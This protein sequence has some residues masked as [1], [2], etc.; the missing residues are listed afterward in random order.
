VITGSTVGIG[1]RVG[2]RSSLSFPSS[3][4]RLSSTLTGGVQKKYIIL[5]DPICYAKT[6]LGMVDSAGLMIPMIHTSG[7]SATSHC[8][9]VAHDKEYPPLESV[10]L[11]EFGKQ[12]PVPDKSAWVD[13]AECRNHPIELFFPTRGK[14]KDPA[15]EIC[16]T[17][18][19]LEQC[20]NHVMELSQYEE[21]IGIWAGL[22]HRQRIKLLKDVSLSSSRRS[23]VKQ[24]ML[25]R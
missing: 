16:N 24:T 8:V 4:T 19:V 23:A 11:P 17:C 5:T 7:L 25:D 15:V 2:T 14:S 22:S 6:Q 21:V 12:K 10:E 1:T 3:V 18:P 20:F 9:P 13:Q